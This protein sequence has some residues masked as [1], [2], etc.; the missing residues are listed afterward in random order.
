MIDH[1]RTGMCTCVG[2]LAPHIDGFVSFL[3]REGYS[4]CSVKE[5][6]DLIIDLSRWMERHKIPLH[7]LDEKQPAQFRVNRRSRSRLQ[8]RKDMCAAGQLLH[9]CAISVAFLS[10]GPR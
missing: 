1:N 8:R 7:K 4:A 5:K 10:G 3:V 9:I 6:R 2:P